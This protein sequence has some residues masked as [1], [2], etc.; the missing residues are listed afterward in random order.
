V[1][2]VT[3][4]VDEAIELADRVVVLDQGRIVETLDVR[5]PADGAQRLEAFARLRH[6]LLSLLGV[7]DELAGTAP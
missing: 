4:D 5:L 1:L 6:R 2:L 3:H 7:V